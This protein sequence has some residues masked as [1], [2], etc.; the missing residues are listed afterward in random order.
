MKSLGE[1]IF[2]VLKILMLNFVRKRENYC[3]VGN[4]CAIV[5]Q[6]GGHVKDFPIRLYRALFVIG[7]F[8]GAGKSLAQEPEN[9]AVQPQSC[10][11][12]TMIQSSDIPP[13]GLTITK[14][15]SYC[16]QGVLE[17]EP[18]Q[19][20]RAAI[21]IAGSQVDLIL[22]DTSISQKGTMSSTTGILI[23]KGFEITM[24]G[25][26]VTGFTGNGL[27]ALESNAVAIESLTCSSN[28]GTGFYFENGSGVILLTC[29]AEQNGGDGVSFVHTQ[30]AMMEGCV[31][32]QNQSGEDITF[33]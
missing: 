24:Y 9:H 3:L 7:L 2:R 6:K 5:L 33:S 15:G 29:T 19:P 27:S 11:A 30:E 23:S 28:Q 26:T 32:Q 25:G 8:I 20:G 22:N 31:F 14:A 10:S 12:A 18:D 16:I 13:Q 4:T 17:F 21:T 1:N